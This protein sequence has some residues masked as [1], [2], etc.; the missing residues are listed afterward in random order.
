MKQL[1]KPGKVNKCFKCIVNQ[2][3]LHLHLYYLTWSN[4]HCPYRTRT[5]Q[6]F[7]LPLHTSTVST[8]IP[9]HI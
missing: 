7:C 6:I 3:D 9:C 5:I 4:K 2:V 1:T 8:S